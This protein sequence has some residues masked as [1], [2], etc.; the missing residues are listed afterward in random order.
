MGDVCLILDKVHQ[1]TLPVQAKKRYTLGVVEKLLSDRSYVLRYARQTEGG[2]YKTFTCERSIQ[3]LALIV[4]AS[5]VD[6]I[7][8]ED[9]ILDPIF[10]VENLLEQQNEAT[11]DTPEEEPNLNSTVEASVDSWEQPTSSGN[12]MADTSQETNTILDLK[13]PHKKRP[14]ISVTFPEHVPL[15]KNVKRRQK[16]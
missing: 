1:G 14:I 12:D 15:I 8:E 16:K 13:S 11:V 6:K 2:E 4:R 9:I 3:G 5:R 10:P 7:N